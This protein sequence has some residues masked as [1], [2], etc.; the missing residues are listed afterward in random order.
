[1]S[2]FEY[3]WQCF[4]T[5]GNMLCEKPIILHKETIGTKGRFKGVTF[6]GNYRGYGRWIYIFDEGSGT[7]WMCIE[8]TAGNGYP[9]RH[10]FCQQNDD[11]FEL[12]PTASSAMYK[13]D[14]LWSPNSL[15]HTNKGRVLLKKG[16]ITQ[17]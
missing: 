7:G 14:A 9:R 4:D 8:F 12:I 16:S 2:A 5:D 6:N 1:M 17:Q 10:V 3:V 11:M 13:N 15:L